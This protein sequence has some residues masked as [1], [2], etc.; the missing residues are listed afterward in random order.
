MALALSLGA[1]YLAGAFPTAWLAGKARGVDVGREGSGNY[2]ATNVFRTLG[3][4]PAVL[5]VVVDV[6]KG[7][8]PVA[9]LP[10]LLPAEGVEPMTQAVALAAAAVLGHVYSV[11]LRFRGGKGI[12]TAA[13]AYLA[14]APWALLAAAL[15]WL[16][17]VALTRIVSAASL[18]ASVALL[19]G[20]VVIAFAP[21]GSAGILVGVTALLVLFV[22]WTHRANIGRLLK[23][24]E[25]KI[26]AGGRP[27]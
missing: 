18:L 7:F 27:R 26:A 17:V 23:G 6:A 9:F 16:L 12:G 19:A 4:V 14:L 20:V 25:R 11:F 8:L 2:G 15:V 10:R 24:E 22:F 21:R 3:P 1:A 13:G 5:V